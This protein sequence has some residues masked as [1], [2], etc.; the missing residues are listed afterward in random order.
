[1]NYCDLFDKP[2]DCFRTFR[3]ALLK[4]KHPWDYFQCNHCKFAR[5]NAEKCHVPEPDDAVEPR[6]SNAK[7][8]GPK[9]RKSCHKGH[10][11]AVY[12][13]K[14]ADGRNRCLKCDRERARDKRN[15]GRDV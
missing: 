10:R 3:A 7:R 4:L 12:G 9:A 6:H 13:I 1:M 8:T 15:Y 14:R 11:Y 5:I 2:E